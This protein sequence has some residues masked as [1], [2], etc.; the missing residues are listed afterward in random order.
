MNG[1]GARLTA[2]LAAM[3]IRHGK[4]C[5]CKSLA[6]RMD[7][8]GPQWV[9]ENIEYVLDEMR[10]NA[11][12]LGVLF[13]RL[14]AKWLVLSCCREVE[15]EQ[16][17]PPRQPENPEQRST[18]GPL[19]GRAAP[20]SEPI[21]GKVARDRVARWRESRQAKTARSPKFGQSPAIG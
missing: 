19:V 16:L 6:A 4:E 17:R 9:R 11:A 14:A 18:Q 1:V 20:S 7:S 21:N 13:V 5:S 3:G 12:K 8:N 2:K 15:S 10:D